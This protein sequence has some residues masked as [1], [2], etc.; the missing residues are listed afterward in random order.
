VLIIGYVSGLV[1]GFRL[2][3]LP[4]CNKLETWHVSICA[5]RAD[6]SIHNNNVKISRILAGRPAVPWQAVASALPEAPV[7]NRM[8]GGESGQNWEFVWQFRVFG[9]TQ[10]F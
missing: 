7:A 9:I 5:C 3:F 6:L 4:I 10:R 1:N 2:N 8:E